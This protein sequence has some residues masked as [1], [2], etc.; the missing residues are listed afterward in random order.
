MAIAELRFTFVSIFMTLEV[1]LLVKIYFLFFTI[2]LVAA[3]VSRFSA[4]VVNVFLARQST[5]SKVR[6]HKQV[7]TLAI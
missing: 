7:R 4:D 2:V 3:L 5:T 6:K 1:Y